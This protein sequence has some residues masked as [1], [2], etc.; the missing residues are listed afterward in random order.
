MNNFGST[1]FLLDTKEYQIYKKA[2]LLKGKWGERII[3][4]N[5]SAYKFYS[6]FNKT[7]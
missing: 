4:E 3:K 5:N 7:Y 6:Y 1:K 2:K